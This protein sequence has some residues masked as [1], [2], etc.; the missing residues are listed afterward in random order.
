MVRPGLIALDLD[1]TL[2]THDKLI[3][4]GNRYAVRQAIDAGVHVVLASGRMH[5]ATCRYAHMLDMD[6]DTPVIS[7]NGALVRTV[8]GETLLD[9]PVQAEY[10]DY[11]IEYTSLHGLHLNYYLDDTLYVAEMD[12]WSRLYNER[13]GSVPNPVGDLSRFKGESPTKLIIVDSL[14]VTN[15]LLG[16]MRGHFGDTLYITKTDD[17]YL[18]F[19]NRDAGKGSALEVVARR[20]GVARENVVAFGDN[21]NDIPMLEWAGWSVAMENAKPEVK[22]VARQ[23]G[24]S[25]DQDG[26][27]HGILRFLEAAGTPA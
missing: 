7:Y 24:L 13:T 20:L 5:E 15:G 17:E 14:D 1:G 12:R 6:D 8:G 4:P 9:K 2:L 19:M 26:V 22:Q 10:A 16:P 21:L 3:S 27:S 23:V 18:E 11:I 25:A